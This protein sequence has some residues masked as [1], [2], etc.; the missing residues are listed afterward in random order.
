MCR[1]R[2]KRSI[3]AQ[4]ADP[5]PFGDIRLWDER[6]E[7]RDSG[8]LLLVQQ[9]RQAS[10]LL[11]RLLL[12]GKLNEKVPRNASLNSGRSHD[13]RFARGGV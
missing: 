7:G 6:D 8:G 3:T 11:L 10:L 1:D 13:S 4:S 5:V 2:K 12:S 9:R